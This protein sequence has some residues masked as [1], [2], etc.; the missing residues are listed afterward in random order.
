[1]SAT[2]LLVGVEP[3]QQA[4][5]DMNRAAEKMQAAADQI[6]YHFHQRRQWEEEYL[7]RLEALVDREL[8]FY[9]LEQKAGD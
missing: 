8:K 1:M 2:I 5:A 3:V 6:G 7:Q 9:S 4:A